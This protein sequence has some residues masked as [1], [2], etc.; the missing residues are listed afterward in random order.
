MLETYSGLKS[1]VV[2][3]LGNRPEL[4]NTDFDAWLWRVEDD[5]YTALRVEEMETQAELV[6]DREM[7]DA[8]SDVKEII[9]LWRVKSG[10]EPLL[11]NEWSY[12]DGKIIVTEWASG[13][14][15]KIIYLAYPPRLSAT[16][17]TND[18]IRHRGNL[19]YSGVMAEGEKQL[20]NFAASQ[21]HR[22][23]FESRLERTQIE[24][25]RAKM[26]RQLTGQIMPAI[27]EGVTRTRSQGY[28]Y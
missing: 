13:D 21:V 16:N 15:L 4:V 18:F 19:Y 17:E 3:G 22:A 20:H 28:R 12:R 25:R 7:I 9:E 10:G 2:S 6:A 5:I 24:H 1:A 8:P 27:A 23:D 14:E 11:E 26:R